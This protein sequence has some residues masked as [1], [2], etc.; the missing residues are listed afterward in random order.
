[1]FLLKKIISAMIS[2]LAVCLG[3]QLVGLYMLWFTSKQRHGLVLVTI[4][5]LIM[6][7]M[8]FQPIPNAILGFLEHQNSAI[9]MVAASKDAQGEFDHFP[10]W[11]VVLSGGINPDSSLPANSQLSSASLA[12]LVEAIRI[13]EMHAETK[14]IA[15]SEIMVK[16]A[17][18]LGVTLKDIVLVSA[19]MDT[20]EQ[21]RQVKSIVGSDLHFLVTSASHMSRALALFRKLGMSPIPAPADFWIKR[22]KRIVP[23]MFFPSATSL[24]KLE[25][26]LHEY[27]GIIWA[28]IRNQI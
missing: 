12:R 15:D 27:F 26:A 19:G 21:A 1:M 24:R 5:I 20:K 18:N 6:G 7:F 10:K 22:K 4:G 16:V 3:I 25:I 11:V 9:L 8:S 28:K 17:N 13:K 14:L 23:G 2:P